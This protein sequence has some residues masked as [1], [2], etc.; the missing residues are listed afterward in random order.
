MSE[1]IGK[2]LIKISPAQ[3]RIVKTV[4]FQKL[5]NAIV[6]SS[7]FYKFVTVTISFDFVNYILTSAADY[8]VISPTIRKNP[9]KPATFY[10]P[11]LKCFSRRT[12]KSTS[13]CSVFFKFKVTTILACPF[14]DKR[15]GIGISVFA[16]YNGYG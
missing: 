2:M 1:Q 4:F 11:P 7:D 3:Q 10:K 12:C 5:R 14:T 15:V 16:S 6:F 8:C 9:L 13:T